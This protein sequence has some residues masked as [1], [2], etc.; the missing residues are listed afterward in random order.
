[1]ETVARL[2][3][4]VHHLSL[5]TKEFTRKSQAAR[6]RS[7]KA[8]KAGKKEIARQM[9]IRWKA[10][11][12]KTEKYYNMVS[13]I[14]RVM[15]ALEEAKVV[16]D[17][18][19]ALETSAGE[20]EKIAE[21]VNP[22]KTTELIDEAEEFISQIEEAGDLLA[23]DMEI[24]LGI[25]VEEELAKMETELLLADASDMPSVPEDMEDL[26]LELNDEEEEPQIRTKEKLK[27]EINKLKKEL[28]I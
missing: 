6:L 17:V 26:D 10:Y 1:M 5:K 21:N 3:T 12:L 18:S 4:T 22:T 23:G 9:L 25:D 11:R 8:L 15:E 14:E 24:D 16:Q 7:I 19:G 20:L 13:R 28:D 2:K 27:E